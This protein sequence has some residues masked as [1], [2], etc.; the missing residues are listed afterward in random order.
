MKTNHPHSPAARPT[1]ADQIPDD[2]TSANGFATNE[3]ANWAERCEPLFAIAWI[4]LAWIVGSLVCEVTATGAELSAYDS[5]QRQWAQNETD[6]AIT[7]AGID[8]FDRMQRQSELRPVFQAVIAMAESQLRSQAGPQSTPN[9][10]IAPVA[11]PTKAP[12]ATTEIASAADQDLPKIIQQVVHSFQE[13]M[14][15]VHVDTPSSHQDVKTLADD[16]S[17]TPTVRENLEMESVTVAEPQI[18]RV[19][20]KPVIVPDQ[21]YVP[22]QSHV[23]EVNS[24][25]RVVATEPV[26]T[27][28]V[29]TEPDEQIA[30]KWPLVGGN[31]LGATE[32]TNEGV[33]LNVD[34]ADVRGVFEMLARGYHMNILVAPD[35][36]G[37]VTANV[38]GLSP[39]A[40]LDGIIKMCH[41]NLQREGDLIYV[42]P[43]SKLPADARQLRVFP[44]D[45]A[46]AESLEPTVQGLL[47]PVGN[48]FT[49]T[50]DTQD[51]MRTQETIVVVDIPS[52]VLQVED[53]ILQVDHAP[54]QVMIE[55]NILEV[56]LKDDMM[57]GINFDSILG[58][59]ISVGAFGLADPIAAR[60]NPLFFAQ[61]DGSKI[62]SLIDLL[63]TTTDSKTLAS[64][65]LQVINGQNARIQVGEQLGYTVATVTQTSTIQDV[66][67]LETGVVL[68]VTPTISRDNRIL[69]IVKPE[70][71]DGKINTDTLVPDKVTR[72]LETSVLLDNHQG[73]IIGGLIQEK[74]TTVIRK[75]PWLGDV[76]H[77]GK[78]FQRREAVRSKTEIVVA[79]TC[80]IVESCVENERDAIDLQ[81][82]GEPLFQGLLQRNCRPWEPR[83][84]DSVGAEKHMDVNQ[85]NRRLPR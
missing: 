64:P 68:T 14:T 32:P 81:R 77:L 36:K 23:L 62:K 61:I 48:A 75:L 49:T 85:V 59:D 78:L 50:L 38:Q 28:P 1:V 72:E 12:T 44:L 76:K 6:F 56:E 73:M 24:P 66:Q 19:A 47:S 67:F 22:N 39:E 79:L 42:Y 71:S 52:V 7:H 40:T 57:H 69:M 33:S 8:G 34:N 37:T 20:A 82:T 51:N 84:P 26:T 65:R 30:A 55:A 70:V 45:F 5:M 9:P 10:P 27:E 3:P 21:P 46:R 53:Y 41:L 11:S 63:E 83:M 4:A 18:V 31:L 25:E 17:A 15:P 29:T 58:G 35:V 80:H 43:A 2:Q 74:D 16:R 60:T 13:W 54:R